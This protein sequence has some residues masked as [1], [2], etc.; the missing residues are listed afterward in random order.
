MCWAA[1]NITVRGAVH[2]GGHLVLPA[3]SEEPRSTRG[4]GY[5]VSP[6]GLSAQLWG[7]LWALFLAKTWSEVS[8]KLSR[9]VLPPPHP[10]LPSFPTLTPISHSCL[11]PLKLSL[12]R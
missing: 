8:G 1:L 3:T 9:A 4:P 11:K 12:E 10:Q 2:R 7:V 5:L 6:L